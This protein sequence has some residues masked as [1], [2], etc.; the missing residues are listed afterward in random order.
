MFL[1]ASVWCDLV[2]FFV[3][4]FKTY[5]SLNMYNTYI[6]YIQYIFK[7]EKFYAMMPN[8]ESNRNFTIE[9]LNSVFSR[10]TTQVCNGFKRHKIN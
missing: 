1:P 6:R 10:Q 4:S 8:D 5:L 7:R 3:M 2:S 9:D